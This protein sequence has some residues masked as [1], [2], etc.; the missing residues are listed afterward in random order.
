MY[1]AAPV[2]PLL[3][4]VNPV[5]LLKTMPVGLPFPVPEADGIVIVCGA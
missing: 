1:A 4:I 5:V 2:E 3:V